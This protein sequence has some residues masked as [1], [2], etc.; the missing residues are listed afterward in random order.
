MSIGEAE[1][2]GGLGGLGLATGDA[3][4]VHSSL[5]SLGWVE[6]GAQT[7]VDA[8]LSAV[9]PDGHV[10]MPTFTSYDD[11][12]DPAD[13]ESGTGA[14]TEAFRLDER[15]VRSHHPTKSVAVAGPD[16]AALT[17][18][19]EPLRSLG[20]G[21]PLHRALTRGARILLLGVDHTTNSSLHVAEAVA[22]L[23]YRD[24]MA[25][26]Y[27][28]TDD[29]DSESVTVNQVHCSAGFNAVELLVEPAG[30][31]S[32]GRIG[33]AEVRLLEGG[34]LLDLTVETLDSHPGLLLCEEPD[35]DRCQYARRRLHEE[36][37]I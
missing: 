1:I 29:G 5:S 3:V 37:R 31:V 23:P 21:S 11:P 9:G 36:G 2:R 18:D 30:I 20:V 32:R 15:T 28:L 24:Q 6:G 26:T 4:I 25:E 8:L 33:E 35:C 7:V 17:E 12:Y 27:R 13:S 22:G 34:R 10:L 14:I 16:A 19:H